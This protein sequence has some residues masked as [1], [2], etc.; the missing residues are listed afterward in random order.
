R[1][2]TAICGPWMP[3]PVAGT[4]PMADEARVETAVKRRA[5][6]RIDAI[7]RRIVTLLNERSRLG[8]D[9]GAA[10]A[11]DGRPVRDAHRER[12]VLLRVAAANDGPLPQAALLAVYRRLM[13]ATRRLEI[14]ARRREREARRREREAQR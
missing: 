14:G 2:A 13:V 8:L 6:R 9:V 5:R 10:K 4:P 3:S 1:V 11:A 7:D 12:E